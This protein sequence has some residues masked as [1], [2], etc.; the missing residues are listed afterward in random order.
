MEFSTSIEKLP[1]IGPGCQKRLKKLGIE[2]IGDLIYHFPHRYEDFSDI[3]PISKIKPNQL[4]RIQGKISDIKNKRIWK[5]KISITEGIVSDQSGK[6]KIIWFNKPYLINSFNPENAVILAGKANI[7]KNNLYLNN[8]ICECHPDPGNK[9]TPIYSETR[10]IS[11][12]WLKQRVKFALLASQ[13]QINDP[14][15]KEILENFHLPPIKQALWQIHFPTS[16]KMAERAQ[17]RFAF[18]G[19]FL[20][21]LAVL[22]QRARINRLKA[23]PVPIKLETLQRFTKSLPFKLTDAQKKS[24]WRILKDMEKPRPM[25]R[26]LEGDVGSGKTVV[27]A[28]AILNTVKQGFQAAVMAPTEVLSKQHF[29]TLWELLRDFKLDVGLLTGKEDKFFSKKLKND[30]IEVSRKKLLEKTE[31]GEID[32]LIGT[33]ALIQDKIKSKNLALVIVDEQHRFG[34]GQR[35]KLAK[36]IKQ[37]KIKAVPHL[38]SM[39][40]TPIPRTL[41]MTIYG[42]LDISLINELPKG[43]KKVITKLIPP[44][45]REKTYDFIRREIKSGGQVFV[46]CPRIEKNQETNS[47]I[48]NNNTNRE[49]EK[50]TSKSAYD[51]T[52]IKSVKDEYEKLSAGIFPDLRVEMLHGK[53]TSKEKEK[54]MRNFK[55]KKT[56]ILVSTSVIEVGVD[57]PDATVMMIEGAERFGLAQLHQ[58]RGRVGR[59]IRRSYCFLFTDSSAIKTRQRLRALIECQNGFELAEKDLQIRGP[60]DFLGTRQWGIPDLAMKSLKNIALVEKTRQAANEILE[61]NPGLENYPFLKKIV[62]DFRTK[63]HLE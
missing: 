15:P 60:G 40:A 63:I 39:T 3:I 7:R 62:N 51:K 4:C 2:T 5:R 11:S 28:L 38:L 41:A 42:D 13:T 14:L 35:A 52:E 17:Q 29:K 23:Q 59:N 53:L 44:Q 49:T 43:R 21:Q 10:G 27:A 1:Q 50:K 61:K 54:I 20:V 8:P 46:V 57:I 58:F 26:L 33:H 16:L 47:K 22:S 56:D 30:T 37:R 6:I 45:D 31:N 12:R 32:L 36:G 34:V 25:N 19:L 55:N 18:E 9:I 48:R 24:G